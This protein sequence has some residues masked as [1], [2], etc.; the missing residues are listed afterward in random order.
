[1]RSCVTHTRLALL[2]AGLAVTGLPT[3]AAAQSARYAMIVQGASGEDQY[4]AQHRR[5]V[6]SLVK[7]FRDR[8]K[9]DPAHL[10]VLTEK[11]GAGE[12]RSTAEGVRASLGRLAKS[13]TASDQLVII[14]IGH[15]S[16]QGSDLKF[17]LIG[18]DLSVAEWA[19]ALSA[20]PGRLA[21]VNTASASFPFIGALAGPG[22]VVITAT[23]TNAQ[24]YHTV[25]PEGFVEALSS[26]AADV[27]KNARISLLEA[28]TYANRL[29][30]QH[31]ERAGNLL[32]TETAALDDDGDGKPRTGTATGPDGNVAGLTFLD[33]AVVATSADPEVQKL[34][35]RQ[36]VL[37]EQV[38]D[39]R[40]RQGSMPA[41][42]YEAELE[43]LLTELAVVSRDIRTRTSK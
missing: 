31:Y 26:D 13:L 10:I 36:Q 33:A 12:E 42:Q 23:N 7:I 43:K 21:M 17:N 3:A 22:R 8:F 27:D 9:Y 37:T 1:M 5:W 32:A 20:I 24:R 18:P 30:T 38:D 6:D 14:L 11:P 35:A 29:V 4:A 16:G 41:A 25:F 34:L 2:L 39:L 19:T 15:G 40:R 28:F